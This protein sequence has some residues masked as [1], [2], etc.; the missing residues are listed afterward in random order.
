MIY[1]ELTKTA[2]EIA[3]YA[4]DGAFDKSG[5]PYIFH[6]YHL[7][8]QMGDDE[9][10]VCVAL[11]HDVIEDTDWELMDLYDEGFPKEVVDA[12]YL[13]THKEGDDYLGSYIQNI[14]TNPIARKVK[15]ADLKHNT[16]ATRLPTP[17]TVIEQ[18][19]YDERM[20]RY[21][22]AIEYLEK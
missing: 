8:E 16:D 15:L 5:M 3:Y 11:L 20:K 1:T 19:L 14:K 2:M 21:Q 12:V 9:Y 13:L 6:P 17:T 22:T 7:A 4:H 10:A 18:M